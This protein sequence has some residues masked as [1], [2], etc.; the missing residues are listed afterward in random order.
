[1]TFKRVDKNQ[2]IE[3]FNTELKDIGTG[4][5]VH[6]F[7]LGE[8]SV[9]YKTIPLYK[10]LFQYGDFE[11][12]SPDI[13]RIE[14]IEIID[15][16][17]L[18][19]PDV[20]FSSPNSE[21]NTMNHDSVRNLDLQ[22]TQDFVTWFDTISSSVGTHIFLILDTN[23]IRRHYYSNFLLDILSR[24]RLKNTLRILIPRL[25]IL[26]I[27]NKYNRS[28]G[29]D[30]EKSVRKEEKEKKKQNED[31]HLEIYTEYMKGKE[32]RL[33]LSSIKEVISIKKNAGVTNPKIS[34]SLL[35]PFSRASGSKFADHWIRKE[36]QEFMS[37]L[38]GVEKRNDQGEVFIEKS[39]GILLT[40]D[41]MNSLAAVSENINT[42]YILRRE[43][44]ELRISSPSLFANLV[45]NTAIQFGECTCQIEYHQEETFKVTGMWKGK[46]TYDWL[47]DKL[48]IANEPLSPHQ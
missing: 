47:T 29:E 8:V 15:R 7:P 23:V 46:T 39:N 26:E 9:Y 44:P 43:T 40:C 48:L 16:T 35:E 42:F 11:I 30:E 3:W 6:K 32:R 28:S 17:G 33:G 2:L 45:Y 19:P 13:F 12:Q 18:Y 36:I 37:T 22:K 38:H 5:R 10:W 1:M 20:E 31:P 21:V 4:P 25:V 14:V 27:E 34:S 41:I 24:S